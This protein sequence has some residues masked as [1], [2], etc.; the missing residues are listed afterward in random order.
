MAY[1]ESDTESKTSTEPPAPPRKVNKDIPPQ[2]SIDDFWKNFTTKN[3]GKPFTILPENLY[4][5]RA[6]IRASRETAPAKNAVASYEQAAAACRAKVEKIVKDCRRLN[7]KYK[8]PHFDIEFDFLKWGWGDH[9]EDCLATLDAE[10][11]DL[12][13]M[14][15]K[16]VEVSC[17]TTFQIS[18]G[19]GIG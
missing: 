8:D 9:V 4:A 11:A 18:P 5:K 17:R 16:R 14:S 2:Q 3:P 13:P 1:N 7:Q 6:A 10:Q 19:T 12:R 15:V